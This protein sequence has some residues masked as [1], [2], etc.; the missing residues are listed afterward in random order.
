MK[1][2]QPFV[3]GDEGQRRPQAVNPCAAQRAAYVLTGAP[4]GMRRFYLRAPTGKLLDIVD[5]G[6]VRNKLT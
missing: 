4:W 2:K 5:T 3:T 1:Q 6:T